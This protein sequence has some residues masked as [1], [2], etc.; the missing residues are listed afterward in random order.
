MS[1]PIRESNG[2]LTPPRDLD[3]LSMNSDVEV[4][5]P[6]ST[7][8]RRMIYH[9]EK[10]I[11]APGVYDGLSA[12]VALSVGFDAMY[13]VRNLVVSF[14]IRYTDR[15]LDWCGNNSLKAGD[16]GSWYCPTS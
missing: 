13:M 10:I 15:A 5:L 16:G 1:A 3:D 2:H 8:L 14:R 9:S 11:V 7:R 6:A 12:R 4:I